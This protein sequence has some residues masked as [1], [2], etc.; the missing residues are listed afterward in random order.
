MLPHS[1][2]ISLAFVGLL[3]VLVGCSRKEAP[4]SSADAGLLAK[5]AGTVPDAGG[6]DDVEP[7]Y[8]VDPDAPVAPLAVKLCAAL[9]E[10]PEK[11]RAACC[12]SPPGIV[13]TSECT[14]TLSAAIRDRSVILTEAA[15]DAC[16]AAFEKT[17]DG[18]DWVGPFGPPPPAA[19]RG[20]LHG[21]LAEG[22]RC[23]SSLECAGALR[24]KGVGPTTRG[25]CGPA[26]E[27]GELC[28]GT[29]DTLATYVRQ[30]NLDAQ[31]PECRSGHCIKH[32]C[33]DPI[34]EGGA[35]QSAQDCSDGLYCVPSSTASATK[36]AKPQ[37]K[38][39]SRE[40]PRAGE[41]CVGGVC[42]ADLQCISGKCTARKATGETCSVD[43][44]C[45]GGCLKSGG[46]TKGTCGPR[47]D[48]R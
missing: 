33:A 45:R 48:V 36:G 1:R 25:K 5:A 38:C 26:K 16:V 20:V 10:M 8:K 14:R 44:E 47:C 7:V 23:R 27:N 30:D 34:A 18:C 42:S 46:A 4:T 17:L 31:H 40:L 13:M 29:T 39:Q 35:C 43:F 2:L 12:S 41:A 32:R 24:C 21:T 28:G 15:V 11:R 19:C 37:R 6:G 3:M 9:T 22:A